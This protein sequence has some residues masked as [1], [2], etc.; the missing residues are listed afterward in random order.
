MRTETWLSG[1][2]MEEDCVGWFGLVG[3]VWLVWFGW[4]GLVGL[5]WLVWLIGLVGKSIIEQQLPCVNFH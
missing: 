3:L 2:L 5:V 4:F 1:I